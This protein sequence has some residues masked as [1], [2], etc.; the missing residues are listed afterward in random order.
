V[1][2]VT[3][4][5]CRYGSRW[6]KA[7][8]IV[9]NCGWLSGLGRR[10]CC[11]TSHQQVHGRTTTGMSWTTRA[12]SYP[13]ALVEEWAQLVQENTE[14]GRLQDLGETELKG[15]GDGESRK[16]EKEVKLRAPPCHFSW[17]QSRRW[18]R[19]ART[20]WA[21][22]EHINV[23]ECRAWMMG[24]RHAGR[25]PAKR[26]LRI[27]FLVDSM[28]VL[29]AVSKGRSSAFALNHLLRKSAS[30][31]LFWQIRPMMRYVPTWRNCAD[32]PSRGGR[33]GVMPSTKMVKGR[34]RGL[35]G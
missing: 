20:K 14:W 9:T 35:R 15:T 19:V 34:K 3:L 21:R 2:L 32:G 29:G 24:L 10:C 8:Q 25:S 1:I 11:S 18:S 23:L 5:Q 13:V 17:S 31:A 4:D 33:V 16:E 12:S 6:K 27:L 22:K 26:G 30:V 28:V 7:T